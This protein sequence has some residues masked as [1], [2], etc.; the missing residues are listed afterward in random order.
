LLP[1]LKPLVTLK[2]TNIIQLHYES[3][4]ILF[5]VAKLASESGLMP[6]NVAMF[7]KLPSVVEKTE[8]LSESLK[9][10]TINQLP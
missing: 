4:S 2:V 1:W 10:S 9:I 8:E 7:M 3:A 5:E 6:G